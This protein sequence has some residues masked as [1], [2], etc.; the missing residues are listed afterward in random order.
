MPKIVTAASIGL[1]FVNRFGA[2]GPERFVTGHHTAGPKDKSDAHAIALCKSYHAA[3]AAKGWGGEGYHWCITRRG[4]IIGLRP[5]NLKGAHVGGHNTSNVGVMFHGTTG[6]RPSIRQRRAYKWL[7]E[8]AHTTRMPKAHRTD[9]DLRRA[10]LRGHNDW[11][12]HTSNACP[13][14]HKKMILSGGVSR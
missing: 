9:R 6:D 13:G 5:T 14:T 8:N 7:L 10:A 2:L 12:G 1:R 11:P 3:H 4:T